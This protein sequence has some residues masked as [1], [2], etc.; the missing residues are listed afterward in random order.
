MYGYIRNERTSIHDIAQDYV[1][2]SV[3][4]DAMNKEF[5]LVINDHTT[6][7]GFVSRIQAPL[8]TYIR[9]DTG[10]W[11]SGLHHD[12]K[13]YENIDII[14]DIVTN[15]YIKYE[16]NLQYYIKWNFP[17]QCVV[18]IDLIF[19]SLR[20]LYLKCEYSIINHKGNLRPIR[21]YLKDTPD[22]SETI[23]EYYKR[24]DTDTD[25]ESIVA[26]FNIE[27]IIDGG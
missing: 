26:M 7:I 14:I 17:T 2:K 1:I 27:D 9:T 22:H 12:D 6:L 5:K 23:S 25:I 18:D 3:L 15:I 8:N 4:H 21:V 11:Y 13:I 20:E 24:S 10:K 16:G 19:N